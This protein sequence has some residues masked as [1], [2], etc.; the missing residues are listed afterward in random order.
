M[1][2]LSSLL[3]NGYFP[4]ELPPSLNTETFTQV[5]T[6]NLLNLPNDLRPFGN[7]SAQLLRFSVSR[8]NLTRRNIGIPNPVPFVSLCWNI[9]SNWINL[10][11]YLQ[12][13]Q[14]S[15]STPIDN[16]GLGRALLTNSTFDDLIT[17]RSHLRSTSR[18]ILKTDITKFYPSIYTHSIAW[19]LHGKV[20]AK[21]NRSNHRL[22]GNCLDR[23]IRNCQDNQSIGIPI[24]PDTS[25]VISE[26]V[27][28]EI[29]RILINTNPEINGFRYSDDFEFE[30]KSFSEA[31]ETLSS[32]QEILLEYEL[33]LNFDK[34]RI[35]ELPMH[36][37]PI[38]LF[39][40][41]NFNFRNSIRT[42]RNDLL[43]YMSKSFE[44]ANAYKEDFVLKYAV[45]RLRS[46]NVFPQNIDIVQDF[47]LQCLMVEPGT[48]LLVLERLMELHQNG[49]T[50][51]L[52]K[53]SETMNYQIYINCPAGKT[54][55]VAWAL[56]AMIF[57]SLSIDNRASI[58]LSNFDNSIIALLALDANSRGLFY[59]PV[60]TTLWETYMTGEELYGSQWLLAYEALI[61][62]WLPSVNGNDY[63]STDHSFR[64]LRNHNVDF[65]DSTRLVTFRPAAIAGAGIY[66][67][68]FSQI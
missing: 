40:L 6:N 42:Q 2:T 32:L 49:Y 37:D 30:F 10:Q 9:E 66:A 17:Y 55:E 7:K 27:L 11:N 68:T 64:F 52:N 29:D 20:F 26:I 12:Q 3:L 54:S 59:T 4:K 67:S 51:D 34:T 65:Y 33:N 5:I 21:Q 50:L 44:Y 36:L 39:E 48:F 24:G 58:A 25:L 38:W 23:K 57:W 31:E 18:Y 46:L 43:H 63:I 61:K 45:A 28:T 53:I 16:Q 60:D 41:R 19:A 14:I 22:L 1:A 13:S 8:L 47:L 15:T 56:W 35:I 62:N